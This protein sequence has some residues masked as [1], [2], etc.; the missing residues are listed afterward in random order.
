M[1][2]KVSEIQIGVRMPRRLRD[3]VQRCA[4]KSGWSFSSQLRFELETIRGWEHKPYLPH[5][6][7]HDGPTRRRR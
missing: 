5:T 1:M 4:D 3:D 6:S 7:S 2:S